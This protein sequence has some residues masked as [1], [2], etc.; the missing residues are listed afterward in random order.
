M[1]VLVPKRALGCVSVAGAIQEKFEFT[2]TLNIQY[3]VLSDPNYGAIGF[4]EVFEGGI[5]HKIEQLIF[6]K[7][8]LCVLNNEQH[9]KSFNSLLNSSCQNFPCYKLRKSYKL[10]LKKRRLVPYF[11]IP[12]IIC[13]SNAVVWSIQVG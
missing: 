9:C 11:M 10:L 4:Q 12:P 2:Q 5:Y 1:M 3:F 6:D 7:Y 13:K 8:F